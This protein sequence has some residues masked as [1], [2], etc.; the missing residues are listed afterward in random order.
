MFS[1]VCFSFTGNFVFI[2]FLT[3]EKVRPFL[4]INTGADAFPAGFVAVWQKQW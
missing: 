3:V 2:F 4:G 1:L